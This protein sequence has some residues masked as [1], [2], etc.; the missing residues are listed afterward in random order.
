MTPEEQLAA[1]A[2]AAA[3]AKKVEFTPEQQDHINKLFNSR[4]AKVTEKHEVEMKLM[5]EAIEKLKTPPVVVPPIAPKEGAVEAETARQMKEF[6]EA[7]K[8][9]T[10]TMKGLLDAERAEKDKV[11]AE[12]KRILKEAA[13]NEAASTLPNGIEFHELKTV[14][15]LVEDDIAFDGD[16]GQWVVKEN[17][18]VKLNSS[19]TPMTLN[20]YF[21]A[22]AAARPYLV[23]GLTKGG[24]GSSESSSQTSHIHGVA[25]IRTKADVKTTKDKVDFI[26]KFGY[27]SWAKLPTK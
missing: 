4:F 7:E 23:K 11:L 13:I 20:E 14:K 5:S 16:S 24:T 6:L 18:S 8:N 2:A 27:E 3:A 1:D 25:V 17:G 19:M 15:K 26:S 9:N 12:N 22:F 21:A 10:K